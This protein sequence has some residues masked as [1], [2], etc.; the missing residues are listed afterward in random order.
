MFLNKI[1]SILLLDTSELKILEKIIALATQRVIVTLVSDKLCPH[2]NPI[3]NISPMNTPCPS[4]SILPFVALA[5]L[6]VCPLHAAT[7]TWNNG[8][9]TS[10]WNATDANWSGSTWVANSDALFN[11]TGG[12]VTASGVVVNDITFNTSGY[13]ISGTFR[14]ANDKSSAITVADGVT[15]TISAIIADN[16]A[17]ASSLTKSGSGTLTLNGLNTYGYA[18]IVQSGTLSVNTLANGGVASSTGSSS[19]SPS[20]LQLI[21]GATLLYTGGGSSTDRALMI[22]YSGTIDAS[23]SGALIFSNTAKSITTNAATAASTSRTITLT[24]TN[25]DNNTMGL[26]IGNPATS[27]TTNLVKS[28]VGTWVL[29][30]NNTFTGS[31][32][33]NGGVLQIGGIYALQYSS[34]D[35]SGT[36]VIAMGSGITNLLVGGLNGSK[37]LSSL[38]TGNYN[39]ITSITLNTAS[40]VTDTYSGSISDGALGMILTKQNSGTQTLSGSNSYS[41]GTKLTGGQLNLNNAYAIGTGT[42]TISGGILGNTSGGAITLATNNAQNWTNEAGFSYTSSDTLNLGT[43]AVTLGVGSNKFVTINVTSGN[44]V[45]GGV[46]SGTAGITKTGNGSLTLNGSNTYTY[47]TIVQGGTLAVSTLANGG[48]ASSIGSSGTSSYLLQLSGGAALVYTGTGV[49]TDRTMMIDTAGIIDN[50][51]SGALV[52]SNTAGTLANNTSASGTANRTITLTGNNTANNIMGLRILDPATGKTTN[53]IKSGIGYWALTGASTYSG[54][55]IVQSGILAFNSVASG[56]VAQALGSGTLVTLGGAATSSGT[57]QYT[58]AAGTLDK[59]IYAL[60][61]G[62]NT[63]KNSGSGLLILSGSLVKNG[64][65]LVLNG[66]SSGINVTGVISGSNASY[67]SDLYVTGDSV[68]LS[69]VNTYYGPTW[70]YGGGV[71]VNGAANVLPTN[72]ALVL[73]GTSGGT[74]NSSNTYN[75]NGYNQTITSLTGTGTGIQTVTNGRAN[76]TSTLTVTG[77]GTYNGGI[78][79]GLGTTALIVSGG[80][81]VLGGSN[82]YTGAT[83]VTGGTLTVNGSLAA[84]SAVSVTGATLAG[85]GTA[86]GNVSVTNGTVDG[87]GLTLGATTFDGASTL[88]G[89]TNATSITDN[90]GTLTISGTTTSSV[91]VNSGA[92]LAGR[93]QVIG[94]VSGSSATINGSGLSIG[95]TTLNGN[96]ALSGYNIASSVTVNSGTTSLTGTTQST[97]TLS[98]SAGATLNANGT[99]A[100]SA[101][102]SGW[103]KGN[104]T[105]TENLTLNSTAT[106]VAEVSGTVA[107]ISYDQ[108]KVNGIVTLAGTLDLRDLG[109]LTLGSTITL[110]DN[111][112][113]GTTTGYFSTI[114]TSGSTYTV[115]SNSD[116]TFTVGTTEYLLSYNTDSASGANF[117]DVTLTVVP[118][119]GTWVMLVGGLG[120]LAF[121]QRLRRRAIR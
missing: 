8:A 53:L 62:L 65:I 116:Y 85:S 52:F 39:T 23:G 6:S 105:V 55:T 49:L 13:A 5:W 34:I 9:N 32:L 97:G 93:G 82:G 74:D 44:L 51:G 45:V 88:A 95:A 50:E 16:S 69:A 80:N 108:V 81:L 58:G 31:T 87:T 104:S 7:M 30:G 113:S 47:A 107:G 12:T 106:L 101:N 61:N 11:A 86:N 37:N 109:G 99:I 15:A 29:T 3:T 19:N 94:T 20:N 72:T 46:I 56:A 1:S 54:S 89:I 27:G 76:T 103:L 41:G 90:S 4:K 75:L 36:G 66:G 24:G 40:G 14:L 117:N 79:N 25:T 64:T 111:T 114:I 115:T 63:V 10:L 28:G 22:D 33:I 91:T 120:M 112:G 92:N 35:T 42:L 26:M 110:I 21:S 60:G 43:G 71:L 77:G 67:N 59:T 38:I 73:G 48:V 18:T 17:G 70:V 78:V 2:Q 83:A 98:V 84:G 96:S 118:E 121:G 68:T 102:I 57:L 119:P 100:G